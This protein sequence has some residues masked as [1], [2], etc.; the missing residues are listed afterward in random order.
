MGLIVA[1]CG[2]MLLECRLASAQIRAEIGGLV[3]IGA[4]RSD[5]DAPAARWANRPDP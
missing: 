2:A 3:A 5:T 4:R 1:G